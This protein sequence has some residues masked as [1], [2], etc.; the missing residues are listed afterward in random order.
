M[1]ERMTDEE[2]GERWLDMLSKE[3]GAPFR[4]WWLSFCDPAKP[5]GSQFLGVAIVAAE[6]FVSAVAKARMGNC[7]PG[8][9]VM[10]G[11]LPDEFAAVLTPADMDRLLTKGEAVAVDARLMAAGQQ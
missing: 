2:R 3:A 7:N 10:G 4:I 11:P 5:A 6:G 9:E 8:G 1:T